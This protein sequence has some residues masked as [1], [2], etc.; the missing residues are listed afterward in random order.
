MGE[1]ADV[2]PEAF[3]N[4]THDW[5]CFQKQTGRKHSESL[6]YHWSPI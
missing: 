3:P 4:S 1:A 5:K 6:L 2:I